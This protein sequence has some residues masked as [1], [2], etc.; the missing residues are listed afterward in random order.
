MVHLYMQSIY[1]GQRPPCGDTPRP[2]RQPEAHQHHPTPKP[3]PSHHQAARSLPHRFQLSDAADLVALSG[4]KTTFCGGGV[5]NPN[6][7]KIKLHASRKGGQD[8]DVFHNQYYFFVA[9]NRTLGVF[10]SDQGLV[11][12]DPETR[13]LVLTYAR[14]QEQWKIS[15]QKHSRGHAEQLQTPRQ[16]H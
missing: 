1:A 11:T 3:L 10:S 13:N 5:I 7:N 8:L 4:G 9:L 12:Q 15:M 16:Y 6:L 2:L 14:S